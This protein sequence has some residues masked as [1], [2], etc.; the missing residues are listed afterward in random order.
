MNTEHSVSHVGNYFEVSGPTES[1]PT[2][3]KLY[4]RR[5]IVSHQ[6]HQTPILM[7]LQT[8]LRR[9]AVLYCTV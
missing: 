1:G 9:C 4:M 5:R 3:N 8:S 6:S 7:G 2:V